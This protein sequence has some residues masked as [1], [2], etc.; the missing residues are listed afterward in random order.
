LATDAQILAAVAEAET[1]SRTLQKHPGLSRSQIVDCLGRA[2]REDS[3]LEPVTAPRSS[4]PKATPARAPGALERVKV[5][6]D[7]AARG[8]PGPAGAGA[9]ILASDGTTVARLGRYLG[10]ATNN[11]AEYHGLLLGLRHALDLGAREL[12]IYADSQLMIRQL[13]GQYRVRNAGLR[14]LFDEAL[15]LL[16]S[17]QKYELHHIPR[18]QNSAADEM[19]NRAI[20]EKM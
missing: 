12:Q 4:A 11:F 17:F 15:R 5:F 16:R 13:G 6:S 9:V 20:D 10:E 1:F 2:A 14:P 7:G 18:E 8:N 3:T 19:S